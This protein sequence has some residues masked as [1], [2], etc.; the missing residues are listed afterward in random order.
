MKS[1]TYYKKTQQ[2][3]TVT[4]KIYLSLTLP[5]KI[6]LMKNSI[7][8]TDPQIFQPIKLKIHTKMQIVHTKGWLQSSE[9]KV[10]RQKH[11][12]IFKYN[13]LIIIY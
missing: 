11:T 3:L 8:A 2:I 6:V 7:N 1:K 4:T 10:F 9:R 12:R 5:Y 13:S